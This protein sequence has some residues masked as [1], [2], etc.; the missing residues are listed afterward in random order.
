MGSQVSRPRKAANEQQ[1]KQIKIPQSQQLS[2]ANRPASS[3]PEISTGTAFKASSDLK[4]RDVM[5]SYSHDDV[6]TMHKLEGKFSLYN[7]L[8]DLIA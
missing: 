8:L 5:I 6:E 4:G 3:K 1:H 7:I 2:P